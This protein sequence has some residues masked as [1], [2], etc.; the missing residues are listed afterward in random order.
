MQHTLNNF[1]FLVGETVMFCQLIENDLKLIFASMLKG[2]FEENLIEIEKD[3]F[4]LMIQKLEKLDYSDNKPLI[5]KS[6]YRFLKQMSKKR[7]HWCHNTYV[8]FGYVTNYLYSN[9][10]NREFQKLEIENQQFKSLQK[11]LQQIRFEAYQEYRK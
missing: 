4:G 6:D 1:H 5:S 8:E 3:T 11:T 2:K 9:E 10:F 7:N